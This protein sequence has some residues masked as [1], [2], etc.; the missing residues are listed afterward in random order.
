KLLEKRYDEASF[1]F[2]DVTEE[3]PR[4][5]IAAYSDNLLK[6]GIK[7]PDAAGTVELLPGGSVK[8]VIPSTRDRIE[9]LPA[10]LRNARRNAA[11]II[12]NTIRQELEAIDRDA[13]IAAKQERVSA[14]KA[15][16]ARQAEYA[17]LEA[18]VA[19]NRAEAAAFKKEQ[20]RIAKEQA[21]VA[22]QRYL[23]NE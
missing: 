22:Q 11:P 17:P 13:V 9:V 7:K 21:Q 19:K 16:H 15:L 18:L 5:S 23:E 20:Q 1:R 14:A 4:G 8:L 3:Y 10:M 12:Q 2:P 6:I